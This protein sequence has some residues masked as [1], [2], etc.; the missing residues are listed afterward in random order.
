MEIGLD[1]KKNMDSK[2][3]REMRYCT[4]HKPYA[5]ELPLGKNCWRER[6]LNV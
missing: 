1:M 2:R 4:S 6:S 5:N 3:E